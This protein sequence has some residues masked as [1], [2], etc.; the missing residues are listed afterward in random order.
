MKLLFTTILM[1]FALNAFSQT[2]EVLKTKNTEIDSISRENTVNS[3]YSNSKFH[4]SIPKQKN[5]S[6]KLS[7]FDY[8][9]ELDEVTVTSKS[10]FNAVSLGIIQKEI[11]PLTQSQRELYTAGDFKP[12][13]LLSLLGGS[14]EF[15][16][17]INAITGR[18][19]RLKKYIKFENKINNLNF[20]EENYTD[21]MRDNLNIDEQVFGIF[22]VHLI[23]DEKINE[24]ISRKDFGELSFYIGDAWFKFENF[25][26]ESATNIKG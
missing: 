8:V 14:M 12:I 4:D 1:V 17:V 21:Y 2:K 9:N 3:N 23:E 22:L 26:K 16:P 18:T 10:E 5:D 11:K 24:L 20:L 6:I 19:K 7:V 25:Q 15:D 13:H